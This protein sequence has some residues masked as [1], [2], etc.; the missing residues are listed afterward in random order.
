MSNVDENLM[1]N[2][3]NELAS[4]PNFIMMHIDGKN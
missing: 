2:Q 4:L 3:A 1:K